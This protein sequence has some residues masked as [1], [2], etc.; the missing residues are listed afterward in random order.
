MRFINRQKRFYC[1][2]LDI[3][4]P[5]LKS[6]Q[7]QGSYH[8]YILCDIR[9]LPIKEKTFDVVLCL[10]VLE[11]LSREDGKQL[12][13]DVEEIARRQVVVTTPLGNYS[14][15]TYDN[16]PYYEHKCIWNPEQLRKLGYK[17]RTMGLRNT[18]GEEGYA[19]R[20]PVIGPLLG[21]IIWVLAG[22]FTRFFSGIA[23]EMVCIKRIQADYHD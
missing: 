9:S 19:Y 12:L 22:P 23:G 8:D 7:E 16:N 14:Q 21:N 6:A 13:M 11:H 18:G 15:G 17:V 2:G 3:F 5:H 20:L 4:A 10:E 1:V